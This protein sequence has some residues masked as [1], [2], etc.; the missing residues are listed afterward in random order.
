MKRRL[1]IVAKLALATLVGVAATIVAELALRAFRPV[2]F[3]RPEPPRGEGREAWHGSIHRPS[4][5]PGLAY[6][7]APLVDQTL[8][9]M[10]VVTNS[11]G[12]RDREP[13]DATTPGLVRV[14]ALGD[15]VTFAYRVEEPDGFASVLER[16]LAASTLATDRVFDVLDV[17]V[18]GYSTRNELAALEGKWLALE[19]RV[20]ILG[21]CMNDPEIVAAQ[22]LQRAFVAPAWWQH[23]HLLRLGAQKLQNRRVRELGGGNYWR[24]LHA[25]GTD[26]W[27][28]VLESFAR[29]NEL[30]RTQH[31]SVVL[32]I[33][34]MFSPT[35]WDEYPLRSVHAQVAAA[36]TE[37]GFVV[38]DLLPRFER[39][40]PKSLLLDDK[41][42]HPNAY[43]HRI[44]AEELLRLFENTPE[45]LQPR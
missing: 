3:M 30:S 36:G 44:I 34:P 17:G 25:P 14:L 7:L 43:G 33:F 22:P 6:E 11:F 5:T 16:L 18:S 24:Y 31:F 23:S 32:T 45:L 42:S 8:P 40:E 1:G 38:L 12:M 28:S 19:P 21:Y 27:Q 29:L 4:T 2:T 15:S 39:E 41:D 9:D 10:H 35:P 20:V 37:Q 26:S 13:L